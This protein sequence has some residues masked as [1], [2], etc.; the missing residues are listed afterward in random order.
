MRSVVAGVALGSQQLFAPAPAYVQQMTYQQVQQAYDSPGYVQQAYGAEYPVAYVQP[1]SSMAPVQ[2][3]STWSDIAMLAVVGAAVGGAI[4]YAAKAR[5]EARASDAQMIELPE[6][7]GG[8]WSFEAK[9]WVYDKWDPESPRTYDNFNPFERNDESAM[10]DTNGCFPGQ[11]R[12]Y[13]SPIR[14]DQSWDIMQKE[15]QLMDE[16]A[17]EPK[18]QSKGKPG[19]FSL[20]WQENLG[21]PQ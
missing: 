4:G 19:N 14:P 12:G 18:F 16:L 1:I 3:G 15:R 5:E 6:E 21:P 17:K 2:Q 13:K 11:S 7:F 8:I 20:K 9:K 10:C